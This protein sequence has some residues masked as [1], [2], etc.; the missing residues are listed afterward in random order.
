MHDLR[1]IREAPEELDTGLTRRGAE[2]AA[3][4]ILAVDQDRRA[5]QTDLQEMLQRR[6][7]VSRQV[8]A[9]K[10]SGEDASTLIAEVQSL[11]KNIADTENT[12]RNLANRLETLLAGLPNLPNANT[13]DGADEADNVEVRSVGEKPSFDF[14]PME[15]FD[16]G[17]ALGLMDF[18][19]AARLSGA[20]FVV[21]KGALARMERALGAFMLDLHTEEHGYTE[22]APPVLVKEGAL[23]NTGQLPKFSEDLFRTSDNYWLIPTAEVPLTNI[24]ADKIMEASAL[25]IRVTAWT[26][27]FRSEAGSAG[28]DTR[29]MLRQH[30]FNKVEMVSVTHPDDS[31]AELERM[32]AC[33]EEVLKQLDIDMEQ[34]WEH[35]KTATAGLGAMPNG[36]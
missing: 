3:A 1:L 35:M 9:V 29:G 18:E 11:K 33:A 34:A 17:E 14:A 20:R 26:S 21:L 6:N 8:G 32:T 19:L 27:C 23:Y 2:P 15:H 30:Q 31:E 4:E 5:A 7:E 10:Q 36:S 12:E 25:P 24:P 13:P 16:L 22:V 28:R